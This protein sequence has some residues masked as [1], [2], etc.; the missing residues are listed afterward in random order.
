MT[1]RR[2]ARRKV[3]KTMLATSM[4]FTYLAAQYAVTDDVDGL[5]RQWLQIEAQE[6]KLVLDWQE[7]EPAVKQRI[8]LLKA[9]KAQ[10]QKILSRSTDSQDDVEARRNE[11]LAEQNALE[12]QQ[13]DVSGALSSLVNQVNALY[14]ALPPVLQTAWDKEEA[15]LSGEDSDNPSK[16]LQVALA[17]L[18]R[19]DQFDDKLTV[20]EE[21]MT[22]PDGKDVVVKQ[23]YMG[24]QLA[25]FASND[26]AIAGS[27]YPQNGEWTWQFDS[28]TDGQAITRA[29]AVFERRQ[30]PDFV[31]LPLPF[32]P[33]S[34]GGR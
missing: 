23:L 11:L 29:I 19:L 13:A 6:R 28:N 20:N 21:V 26:G 16:V 30:Q 32:N 34:A 4:V 22:T 5:T 2:Q 33:A 10:L 9:E 12:Q 7:Q 17:K 24:S 25:W 1:I 31:T 18:S 15:S 27:G 8:E 14:D 3:V